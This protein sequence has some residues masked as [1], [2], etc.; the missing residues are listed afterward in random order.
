LTLEQINRL[1]SKLTWADVELLSKGNPE[2]ISGKCVKNDNKNRGPGVCIAKKFLKYTPH[3][4]YGCGTCNSD[5]I[6]DQL[7]YIFDRNYDGNFHAEWRERKPYNKK[8]KVVV[9]EPKKED[10][11]V[12]RRRGRPPGSKNKSK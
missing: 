12:I 4:D 8:E 6:I 9:V 2:G 5:E 10:V 3:M 7:N 11:P 1:I